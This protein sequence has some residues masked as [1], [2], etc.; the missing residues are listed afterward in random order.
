[1]HA[2]LED[3]VTGI[4]HR[5]GTQKEE[6]L[7]GA[8]IRNLDELR[9]GLSEALGVSCQRHCLFPLGQPLRLIPFS[10]VQ[11]SEAFLKRPQQGFIIYTR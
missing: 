4:S 5:D 2:G 7:S 11:A 3:Q 1:M 10:L 6:Q 8:K 9:C